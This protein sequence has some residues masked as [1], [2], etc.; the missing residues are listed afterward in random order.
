MNLENQVVSIIVRTN[1]INRLCL[2]KNALSSIITNDYRPIEIIVVAQSEQQN[3][4]QAVQSICQEITANQVQINLVINNTSQD[5][6]AKNLN[7]GMKASNGRYIGF[8]DDDDIIYSNHISLLIEALKQSEITAW[9]YSQTVIKICHYDEK[10]GVNIIS[11]ENSMIPNKFSLE[12]FVM[13]KFNIPIHSYLIDRLKIKADM[14]YVDESL[15][16]M[17]DYCFILKIACQ[18]EP[19]YINNVTCEYRFYTDASNSS[20]Y[21]NQILGVNYIEKAKIWQEASKKVEK[22]KRE[23]LPNY[24]PNLISVNQRKFLLARFA[25][26]YRIKIKFPKIWKFLMTIAVKLKLIN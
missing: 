11:S 25:F 2:L 17:E 18:Y 19:V 14:L 12:E 4:I 23:L 26:L 6:R 3:F 24:S 9:A 10:A 13:E 8:L 7:L 1:T 5:E 22:L 21:I 15:R 20:F 16:V